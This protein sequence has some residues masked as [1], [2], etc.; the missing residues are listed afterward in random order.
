MRSYGPLSPKALASRTSV[1]EVISTRVTRGGKYGT[2]DK[3]IRHRTNRRLTRTMPGRLA[4]RW[5]GNRT[6]TK[7]GEA[8]R[9]AQIDREKPPLRAS[10]HKIQRP[11]NVWLHFLARLHSIQHAVLQ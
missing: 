1:R 8:R 3:T 5:T 10:H 7:A 6:K 9:L 4:Q 11:R 2:Q